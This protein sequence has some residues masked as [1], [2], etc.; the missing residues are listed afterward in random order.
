MKQSTLRIAII[1]LALTTAVVHLAIGVGGIAAGRLD[2]FNILFVLNGL[3]FIG[4]LLA[5]FAPNFPFFSSNRGLAHFLMIGFAAV[6]FV[7]YFVFN[8]W[9]VTGMSVAAIVAKLAELLLVI[10]TFLHL[11]AQ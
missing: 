2:T 7:L 11:R 8:G 4:L 9:T 5:L 3:G 1:I 10:A 6:T